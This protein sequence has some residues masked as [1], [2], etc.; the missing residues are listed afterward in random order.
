MN[1]KDDIID[2][3]ILQEDDD[4]LSYLKGEMSEDDELAFVERL[5]K[6]KALKERA[7]SIARLTKGLNKVGTDQDREIKTA[8]LASSE[9]DIAFIASSVSTQQKKSNPFIRK[10]PVWMSIAASFALII[11]S[12][13]GF[14]NYQYNMGLADE[15]ANAFGSSLISRGSDD[16]SATEEK[17]AQLFENIAKKE[18]LG[19]TIHELSLCWE[20]SS[21]ETYN[22]YTDYSVEIGWNLAIGYLKDNDKS[23]AKNVLN[24]IIE[25]N[26]EDSYIRNKA[27]ELVHKIK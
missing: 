3:T 27:I 12:G 23:N 7:V 4:I 9:K 15:Y 17:L 2:P 11:W 21:M 14:Y 10:A 6:D 13:V 18:D 26:P 1:I 19:N 24:S 16:N 20:L 8:M 5:K 22:D 25:L